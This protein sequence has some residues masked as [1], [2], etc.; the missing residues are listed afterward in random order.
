MPSCSILCRF[1][2]IT[3]AACPEPGQLLQCSCRQHCSS[4]QGGMLSS[5]CMQVY[6]RS[7]ALT[8]ATDAIQECLGST[9]V[10]LLLCKAAGDKPE[11]QPVTL[12]CQCWWKWQ[13]SARLPPSGVWGHSNS[14]SA[15]APSS[16]G[17]L[18]CAC[19]R[20]GLQY[21]SDMSF[22]ATQNEVM[23]KGRQQAPAKPGRSSSRPQQELASQC[24]R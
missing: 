4:W 15:V 9:L 17:S 11:Q 2:E 20:H 8:L 6:L 16:P 24:R 14:P 10:A 1:A 13:M 7:Q 3:A 12:T 21:S 19:H 22:L 18:T 23:L 5:I